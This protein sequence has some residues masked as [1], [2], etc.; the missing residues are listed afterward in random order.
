MPI[1]RDFRPETRLALT[2][3]HNAAWEEKGLGGQSQG[4]QHH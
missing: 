2:P 1:V 4:N 3:R